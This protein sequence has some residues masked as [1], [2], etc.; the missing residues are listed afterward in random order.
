PNC[1]EL[2]AEPAR[3]LG[4]D[5]NF[6]FTPAAAR[7]NYLLRVGIYNG[8]HRLGSS[9]MLFVTSGD[10]AGPS[11]SY[12]A[13][14]SVRTAAGSG[15]QTLIVGFAL[16][17]GDKPLL[18]RGIGP[19]LTGFG[20]TGALADPK[21][22]LYRETTLIQSNDNWDAAA[23]ATFT[24]VGAFGLVNGSRDAALVTTLG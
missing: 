14:L 11:G 1:E 4:A 7:T 23:S 3:D 6:G 21:L 15:A 20:V 19:A 16:R 9:D 18:V 10:V 17:G 5:T 13:N 2:L 8:L 22:E 24:S 12:L